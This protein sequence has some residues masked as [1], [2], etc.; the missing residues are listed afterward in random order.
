MKVSATGDH[1]WY[2]GRMTTINTKKVAN[3]HEVRPIVVLALVWTLFLAPTHAQDFAQSFTRGAVAADHPVAS[4]A[5]ATMLR[6]GGN[7]V[8][9]AVASSFTLSVVRP[10]SCGIGGGGFMVIYLPDDPTHGRVVTAINYRETAPAASTTDMF[11]TT[12]LP[13]ASTR[14]GLAVAV[15][16]TVAGLLYALDTYGTLDRATVLQPAIDAAVGGY[17]ADATFVAAVHAAVAKLTPEQKHAQPAL[18]QTLLHKGIIT[19]GDTVRNLQQAGVLAA[20]AEQGRDGFY[21]GRVAEQVVETASAVGG[22]L[23]LEDLRDYTPVE[24]QPV[25]FVYAGRTF[26]AMPPPSS[27]GVTMCEALG[28]FERLGVDA[29]H[30]ERNA[31]QGHARWTSAETHLLIE[32]WKHAFADRAAWLADPA[33]VDIPINTLLSD[34]YLD[35]RASLVDPTHTLDSSMYGTRDGDAGTRILPDD[36]GTSH[37]SVI[38]QWGGAVACTETI[39][40][41]F[42]SRLAVNGG[43][44]CLNN[45][46]DDFTTIRGKANAFGLVQSDRNLPQPGKRPLSSMSPTIVI[47]EQ[48]AVVAVAGASGGPR[49]I[50]GTM[51]VLL[52]TLILG[53]NAADAVAAPRLHHQWLPDTTR[54]EPTLATATDLHRALTSRNH[55]LSTITSVGVVQL[56]VRDAHGIHAACDPR[57]GGAPAGH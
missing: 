50:T 21:A 44:F 23:T 31:T 9:A 41:S 56:I 37:I 25:E 4:E 39:N 35:T 14:S 2:A 11:E 29:D 22:I 15:P 49:I 54:L 12:D 57:K 43:G 3:R 51:Q 53:M 33:F 26:I 7:A 47:D 48:G 32:S 42:G 17:R 20:I 36:S 18:W 24:M 1:G 38:D 45:E 13:D 52:N 55:T 16:G 10:Q 8:D 40:L 30:A 19:E 28:I 5:G 46:M 27:G 34:P 6:L